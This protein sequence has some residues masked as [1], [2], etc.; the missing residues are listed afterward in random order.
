M[1]ISLIGIPAIQVWREKKLKKAGQG[2]IKTNKIKTYLVRL[3]TSWG[4]FVSCVGIY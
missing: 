1:K 4:L 2:K 3:S